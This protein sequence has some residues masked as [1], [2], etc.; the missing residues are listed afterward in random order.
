MTSEKIELLKGT[1][2]RQLFV[3]AVIQA[4]THL[5]NTQNLPMSPV[6]YSLCVT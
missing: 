1:V 5:I 4:C 2:V 3:L 6:V